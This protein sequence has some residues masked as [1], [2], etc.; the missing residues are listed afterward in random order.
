MV[1]FIPFIQNFRLDFNYPYQFNR[2]SIEFLILDPLPFLFTN[3]LI[4]T[5]I[6]TS[7]AINILFEHLKVLMKCYYF[8]MCY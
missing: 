4:K 2:Y 8:N 3:H 7:V 5:F 1:L 6:I